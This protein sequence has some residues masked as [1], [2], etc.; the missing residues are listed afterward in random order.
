MDSEPPSVYTPND[1]LYEAIDKENIAD[2][3][4]E[5]QKQDELHRDIK[6]DTSTSFKKVVIMNR[7]AFF[8]KLIINT[9]HLNKYLEST[10]C[11]INIIKMKRTK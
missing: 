3:L 5:L 1:S 8:K 4:W 7:M 2:K 10:E 11:A 6:P 9:L